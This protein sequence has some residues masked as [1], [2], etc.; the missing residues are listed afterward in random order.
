MRKQRNWTGLVEVAKVS[1][2]GSRAS[3]FHWYATDFHKFTIMQ[4]FSYRIS[5][6]YIL[7][8]YSSLANLKARKLE[9]IHPTHHMNRKHYCD[10]HTDLNNLS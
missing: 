9:Y 8:I 6:L 10:A 3:D 2:W 5:S 7:E 4:L 1:H